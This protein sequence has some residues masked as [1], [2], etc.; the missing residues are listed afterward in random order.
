[1][2]GIAALA[3]VVMSVASHSLP[4]FKEVT[5]AGGLDLAQKMTPCLLIGVYF[6]LTTAELFI[7]PLGLS[8]VSISSPATHAGNHEG[9]CLE[10]LL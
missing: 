8:F 9:C 3:Y 6:I 2:D 5:D 1:M 10:P 4:P 7:N